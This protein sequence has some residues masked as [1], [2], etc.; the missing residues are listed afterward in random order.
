LRAAER[1]RKRI[2]P[3]VF[4]AACEEGGLRA[5]SATPTTGPSKK[6]YAF[7]PMNKSFQFRSNVF[8]KEINPISMEIGLIAREVNFPAKEIRF[9]STEANS[10]TMETWF[11]AMEINLTSVE[12]EFTTKE[13]DITGVV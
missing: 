9:V 5:S 4:R 1:E 10:I 12:I 13:V 2:G 3:G 7:D 6:K 8:C 11:I